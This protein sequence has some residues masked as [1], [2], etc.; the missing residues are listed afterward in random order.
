MKKGIAIV[1]GLAILAG[2]GF[3]IM[4][5]HSPENRSSTGIKNPDLGTHGGATQVDTETH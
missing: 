3:Y 5:P 1:I 2:I 4:R